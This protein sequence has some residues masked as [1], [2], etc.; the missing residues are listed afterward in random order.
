[1]KFPVT[2]ENEWTQNIKK[3]YRHFSYQVKM[4]SRIPLSKISFLKNW[5][6]NFILYYIFLYY[7]KVGKSS[8]FRLPPI[9]LEWLNQCVSELETHKIYDKTYQRSL[10]SSITWNFVVDLEKFQKKSGMSPQ[11]RPEYLFWFGTL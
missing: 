8:L 10:S 6:I 3:I 7:T 5:I 2:Y 9:C 4:S 1:M 11:W